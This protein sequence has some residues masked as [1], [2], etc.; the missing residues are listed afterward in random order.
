MWEWKEKS[1][2]RTEHH[3]PDDKCGEEESAKRIQDLVLGVDPDEQ[4]GNGHTD[5]LNKVC[6]DVEIGRLDVDISRLG[7]TSMFMVTIHRVIFNGCSIT[8]GGA[9]EMSGFVVRTMMVVVMV[10][11]VSMVVV[12]VVITTSFVHLHIVVRSIM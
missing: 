10:V 5:A 8:S 11:I 2:K 12:M 1:Q 3:S 9:Q 7:S 4:P 6:D